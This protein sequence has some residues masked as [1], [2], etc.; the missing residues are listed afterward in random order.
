V[1]FFDI[2]DSTGLAM[3]NA[4]ILEQLAGPDIY[5]KAMDYSSIDDALIIAWSYNSTTF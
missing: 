5:P 3:T 2:L 1:V 4:V